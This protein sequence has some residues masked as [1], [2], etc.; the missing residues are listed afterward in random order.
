MVRCERGV[1]HRGVAERERACAQAIYYYYFIYMFGLSLSCMSVSP[2]L[3]QFVLDG[4]PFALC[5]LISALG[6]GRPCLG[7]S[8]ADCT[9]NQHGGPGGGRLL[10]LLAISGLLALW[11]WRCWLCETKALRK[12]IICS[13]KHC[14]CK[15]SLCTAPCFLL[16]HVQLFM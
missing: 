10:S 11:C 9:H 7:L 15:M 5:M 6:S 14:H 16:L 12:Q 4:F 1:G 2:Y 8:T 13:E 3:G